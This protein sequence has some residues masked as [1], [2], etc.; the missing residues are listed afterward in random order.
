[1]IKNIIHTGLD[2]C[3]DQ[4]GREIPCAGAGQ[5]ASF[6]TGQPWPEPRFQV[7]EPDHVVDLLTNLI[8][9]RKVNFFDFPLTWPQALERIH[10]LNQL[11]FAGYKDWRLPNR[12]EL[13]SIISHGSRKPA[14]P[15]GHPFEDVFLAWYWTS[16]TSAIKPA[17]AWYIHLEGGRMFYGGKNQRYLSWPVRGK[18]QHIIRTGQDNCFDDSGKIIS[19]SGTGQDAELKTGALWPS[20]RFI[21]IDDGVHDL[22]TGLVW[23]HPEKH[24]PEPCTWKQALTEAGKI[25]D[26]SWRLPSINELESLVDASAHSPALSSFFPNTGFKE[27]YWSSTTS[28]FEPDWAHVLYL[29]KGAVGVGHKPGPEFFVWPVKNSETSRGRL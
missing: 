11:E 14:L 19:C 29:H 18:P 22:L 3:F 24:D 17:Y 27:G 20:P 12:R 15:A 16:T 9:T 23:L 7:R 21:L 28:Y 1:M 26:S 13:R 25:Q 10:E 6:K 2:K 5:D 8:W 4:S